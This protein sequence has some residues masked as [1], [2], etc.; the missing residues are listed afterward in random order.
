MYECKFEVLPSLLNL[1]F[2]LV[3]CWQER[4]ARRDPCRDSVPERKCK[5]R[6]AKAS[7]KHKK[8]GRSRVS[9]FYR[10]IALSG[11]A[12]ER[13]RHA[14]TRPVATALFRWDVDKCTVVV[15]VGRARRNTVAARESVVTGIALCPLAATGTREAQ[16]VHLV[17][18]LFA[19]DKKRSTIL[20]FEDPNSSC[21]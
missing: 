3:R 14:T 10:E 20:W 18:L 4:A 11:E 8:P 9:K 7:A 1:E 6:R 13:C 2:N 12:L 15:A 16:R 17:I 21:D 5:H 19:R